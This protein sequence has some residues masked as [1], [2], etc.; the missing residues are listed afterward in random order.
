MNGPLRRKL[1]RYTAGSV[2][3]GLCSEVGFLLVYGTALADTRVA[4]VVGFLAGAIPNYLLNRSWTWGRRGRPDVLREVV[5][6]VAV[7]LASVVA[8]AAVTSFVDR[9]VGEL[10]TS[11]PLQVALVTL[12]FGATYGLLF[13]GKFVVFDRLLFADRRERRSRHQVDSTTRAYRKP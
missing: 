3:A 11:R 10:T 12:A 6:Y 9:H 7:V 1:S 2:I 5:P 4:S 8:A 13:V